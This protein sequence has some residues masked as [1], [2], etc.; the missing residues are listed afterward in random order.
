MEKVKYL[1]LYPFITILTISCSIPLRTS[2]DQSRVWHDLERTQRYQPDGRDFRIVNG[3]LKFNRA[4]YGTHTAFRIEA[5]DLPEF[6]FYMPGMGG[7][8]Q[9]ALQTNQ[10]TVWLSEA[11]KIITRY[12][13]GAMIFQITDPIL[14]QGTLELTAIAMADEEGLILKADFQHIPQG[15][16]LIAIYGGASDKKFSR[17]GDLNADPADCFFLKPE[18]CI[19]NHYLLH[20][21]GFHLIYG[22]K[23]NLR[24]T[25][26]DS[27]QKILVQGHIPSK[28]KGENYKIFTGNFPA[29]TS[30]TIQDAKTIKET[31]PNTTHITHPVIKA[32]IPV[33]TQNSLYLSLHTPQNRLRITSEELPRLYA[34]AEAKRSELS[35]RLVIATPDSFLNTLGGIISTVGDAIYEYPSYMHGA[36]SWRMRLNGWRG[37]YV[38]D[39]LGWHDRAQH[40]FSSYA[41][42]QLTEPLSGQVEMDTALNLTRSKERLGNAMFSSGYI[43]RNPDGDFRPHH[44]D[45]NLVWIDQLLN[46]FAWTGDIEYLKEMWPVLERHL[47][48]EKRVF[49]PD[50]DGLYDAYACIWASDGLMYNSGGVTHSSAYNYKANQKAAA[51]ARKIGKDPRPYEA[52]ANKIR[53]AINNKL[54]LADQGQWA[55]FIDFMG[56]QQV[57]PA[58][59]LW[60]VYHAIDSDVP[61]RFQAYQALRYIDT[62]IP[63]IPLKANGLKDEGYYLLSTTNWL[64]YSWSVNNVAFAELLHTSLAYW[65]GG[66]PEEG[67]KLWKSAILDAMYCGMSPGNIGQISFYDAARGETYR[68]FAD[69]TGMAARSIVEGLFG[70]CPDL[71]NDRLYLRPGFPTDWDQAAIHLPYIDFQYHS[72]G[73]SSNYTI[74]P[75]MQKQV[76][77]SLEIPALKESIRSLT[78]NGQ[79]SP[80]TLNSEKIGHPSVILQM[81]TASEYHITIQWA[82]DTIRNSTPEINAAI[83][84]LAVIDFGNDV[85]A[86]KDPQQLIT[87]QEISDSHLQVRLQ[88]KPG[89]HTFFARLNQG[90]MSWWQP[91]HVHLGNAVEIIPADNEDPDYLC[92]Y[93]RNNSERDLKGKIILSPQRQAWQSPLTMQPKSVSELIRIPARYAEKGTNIVQVL[94]SGKTYESTVVNWEI[95]FSP[96]KQFIPYPIASHFNDHLTHIFENRYLSPRSPYTTLQ[97]PA[98]GMGEW[99]HPK[100]IRTIDDSGLRQKA[101]D[102]LFTTPFGLS[103]MTPSDSLHPNIAFVSLWDNYPNQL[104]IPLTGKSS[105]AYFLMAGT[106][107][108]MQSQF[109]NGEVTVHYTDST[110][111]VLPLRNPETW[112]PIERD[113]YV[114]GYAFAMQQAR[115]YRVVLKT[116]QVDRNL[117]RVIEGKKLDERYIPGGGAIIL[118]LPL[119]PTKELDHLELKALANDV[120]IGIMGITLS[121]K[122]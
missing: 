25:T 50:N 70:I 16:K 99:C 92:F 34:Q 1:L 31:K 116:G 44:Y 74:V 2:T 8:C 121:K 15:L 61:D 62:Q 57:H 63:H 87:D 86:L 100:L 23:L 111:S 119:D 122:E 51:L 96:D 48:W 76:A 6:A 60:T 91:I 118:D 56:N 102:N 3:E 109:I 10:K 12:R 75:R 84:E 43:C 71:M 7:N 68:D 28:A 85:T 24:A 27:L 4:L 78:I 14:G 66:R 97:L 110:T 106:T 52:E 105:H 72:Q 69:P 42:S 20:P 36:I 54:W 94:F 113:Y 101:T 80:W 41:K 53:K 90:Q 104:N 67:F 89:E 32:E 17:S 65:Q 40:T 82:G 83:N 33:T 79:A 55:E 19:D 30:L 117:E 39:V 21:T 47:N 88:G 9:L 108:H 49:D 22:N 18:N 95:P 107:N 114:D 37:A 93:I 120:V 115:P 81:P 45:M 73:D 26:I 35:G 77:V 13:A 11:R 46:H 29:N 64:P 103:F 58:A 38:A 98:Q 112:A 59:G 5:G